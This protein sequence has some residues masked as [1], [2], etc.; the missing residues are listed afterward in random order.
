MGA[1]GEDL[2]LSPLARDLFPYSIECKNQEAI[3]VW[4]A[5]QQAT[6]NAGDHEPLLIIKRNRAQPLAVVDAKH[7]VQLSTGGKDEKCDDA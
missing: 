5:W 1:Q 2:M 7:F 3:N 4:A 6:A